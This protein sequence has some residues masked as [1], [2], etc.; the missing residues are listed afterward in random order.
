MSLK[1][2][3]H[4]CNNTLVRTHKVIENVCVNTDFLIEIMFV[5]KAINS[6][7]KGSYDKLNFTVVAI[8]YEIR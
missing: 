3:D 7:F 4:T 2:Y 6:H 1:S 8:S 5:L